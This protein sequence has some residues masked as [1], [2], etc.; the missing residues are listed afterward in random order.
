MPAAW[1]QKTTVTVRDG[2]I[3]I[4]RSSFGRGYER[5]IRAQEIMW[6]ELSR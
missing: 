3:G 1:L 5:Q 2:A 4:R 6:R